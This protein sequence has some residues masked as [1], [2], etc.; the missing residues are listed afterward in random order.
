MPEPLVRYD[1][2]TAMTVAQ[3]V[4]VR[5]HRDH[6]PLIEA[7]HVVLQCRTTIE[8][9]RA[10]E[11]GRGGVNATYHCDVTLGTWQ[12]RDLV[13]LALGIKLSDLEVAEAVRRL[14]AFDWN[15]LRGTKVWV[16]IEPGKGKMSYLGW[17]K[18]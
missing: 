8:R 16:T 2:T 10:D 3:I 15:E 13:E 1:D 5:V 18:Q 6:D 17:C 9:A 4:D 11:Q 12:Q 14:K 7:F